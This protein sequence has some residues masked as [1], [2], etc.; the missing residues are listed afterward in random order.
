MRVLHLRAPVLALDEVRDQVHR[1]RPEQRVQR[2]QVLEPIRLRALEQLAHAARLELEHRD[3]VAAGEQLVGGRVVEGD[4]GDV[5]RGMRGM[6][7]T[8]CG[9]R[10]LNFIHHSPRPPTLGKASGRERGWTYVYN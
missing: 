1:P 3:G 4:G 10:G 5:E 2:D 6:R 7:G 9:T 8:S